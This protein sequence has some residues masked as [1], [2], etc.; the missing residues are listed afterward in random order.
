MRVGGRGVD[1][2]DID[3]EKMYGTAPFILTAIAK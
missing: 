3:V 1:R 2:R